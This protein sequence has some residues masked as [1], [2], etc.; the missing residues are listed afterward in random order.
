MNASEKYTNVP[1]GMNRSYLPFP[2]PDQELW[3]SV[4]KA[5]F[6]TYPERLKNFMRSKIFDARRAVIDFLP[7]RLDI[8]NV[9]FVSSH[10]A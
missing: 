7:V 1:P 4:M 10:S 3:D 8:E 6:D 2:Y 5:G 9:R